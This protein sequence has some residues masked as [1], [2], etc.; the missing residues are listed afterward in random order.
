M[1]VWGSTVGYIFAEAMLKFLY[2]V[3]K[4]ERDM[5]GPK[6]PTS[7]KISLTL[8]FAKGFCELPFWVQF[9]RRVW[10]ERHLPVYP[11]FALTVFTIIHFTCCLWQII[12]EKGLWTTSRKKFFRRQLQHCTRSMQTSIWPQ[13][14][15]YLIFINNIIVIFLS[16]G[17]ENITISKWKCE[18]SC[19]FE[20]YVK[21]CRKCKI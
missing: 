10:Q 17:T 1:S 8:S 12:L 5:N 3:C 11:H 6:F 18:V 19:S 20:E 13:T 2:S 16:T 9:P 7:W 21:F 14:A 4:G 15:A